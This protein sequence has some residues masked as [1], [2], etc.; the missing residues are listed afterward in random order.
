MFGIKSGHP[1]L[2]L[3]IKSSKLSSSLNNGPSVD[4][5]AHRQIV[6][7]TDTPLV[8]PRR[9]HSV[10]HRELDS[11]CQELCIQ[12]FFALAFDLK[13]QLLF[14]RYAQVGGRV[15]GIM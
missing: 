2:L 8:Y 4:M 15:S 5:R 13:Y 14:P 9:N 12:S 10:R 6:T 1:L 11:L 3:I 7:T